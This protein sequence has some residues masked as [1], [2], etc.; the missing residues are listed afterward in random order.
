MALS[1]VKKID[2]LEVVVLAAG[3]GTRMKSALPKV[4]QPVCGHS[5]LELVLTE[6]EGALLELSQESDVRFGNVAFNV[7]IGHERERVRGCVEELVKK[8]RLCTKVTFTVQDKQ[9]GTGHAVREA[10]QASSIKS[11]EGLVAVLNGDLPLLNGAELAD[12]LRS[13]LKEKSMASLLSTKVADA[14]QYGRVLRK[15]KTFV[16]VV[17]AKD[18]SKAQLKIGEYNGG[19]YLF[20][21]N[22]LS[23]SVSKIDSKNAS[24]EFYLPDIFK[25][26]VQKKKKVYAHCIADSMSVAGVNNMQERAVAEKELYARTAARWMKEGVRISLPDTVRIGPYVKLAAGVTV[27]AFTSLSGRTEIGDGASIGSFCDLKDT[28]IGSLC[29]IRNSVMAKDARVG[30]GTTVGP[31][32]H[33]RPG[34]VLADEVKIGNFVETK[35]SSIGSHTSVAHLSYVGDAE[36]GANVNLGCG[37]VTCN[38]DGTVR[39]GRRKHR[40]KIGNGAFIGSDCQVVAPIELADGTFVASGSTVTESVKEPNSLVVARTRQVTKPGYAAKYRKK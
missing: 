9:L 21:R 30:V 16:G 17:E 7:V 12:F 29:E 10:L 11:T 20:D 6:M 33:L 2:S 1:T 26:A 31:M 27:D 23:S 35:E 28:V 19:V 34:T 36:I 18:A 32:A 15:G 38:Y 8:E 3:Q 13:H 4:L 40:S 14:G 22:M 25:M 37:F 5:M 39:D 24:K